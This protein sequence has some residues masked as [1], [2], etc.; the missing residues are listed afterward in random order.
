MAI[1]ARKSKLTIRDV[2]RAA[3]ASPSTVSRVMTG[4]AFVSPAK[5]EAVLRAMK[6]LNYRP[7]LVARSL[8]TA[9]TLNIGLIITDIQSPFYSAAAKGVQD[10]LL[11]EGYSALLCDTLEDPDRELHYFR[12]LQ[13]KGVD[14][15]IFAPT[16]GNVSYICSLLASGL[17]L[18]Q[19]DRKVV[20]EAS[21]VL[22][23]NF[24]AA[25]GAVT[26]LISRGHRRIGLIAFHQEVTPGIE[27]L[28]GYQQALA[29][30]G[31]PCDGTYLRRGLP[32]SDAGYRMTR[33]IMESAQPP[34][35]LFAMNSRLGIGMLRALRDRGLSI[36][37]DVAVVVFDD[38]EAF[39]L[40]TPPITAVMH[41]AYD[42]GYQAADLLL[43]AIKNRAH[44]PPP[45]EVIL[46]T[47]L[48]VRAS[49]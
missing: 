34:T 5:R 20:S 47:R 4:S 16:G 10:R 19:I 25:Y 42:I 15:I 2:A 6:A 22:V 43:M 23:D 49:S 8:K 1:R 33:E 30:A 35:A 21:V 11:D 39:S 31:I 28:R 41:P 40:M 7:N 26:H 37:G 32:T 12:N 36:P 48:I 44:P 27:R 24:A 18:V 29:D 38:I 3:G 46:P 13:D 9:T 17:P 45:R 14:G